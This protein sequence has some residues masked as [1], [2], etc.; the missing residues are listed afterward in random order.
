[1]TRLRVEVT[2]ADHRLGADDAPVT[3]VE[4]GDYQCPYCRAAHATV[5][6]VRARFGSDLRFVFRNFPL[7]TVHPHALRA[8]EV[9]EFAG[10]H[11][12]F[13]EMHDLLFAGQAR[14]GDPLFEDLA[15]QLGLPLPDMA[16]A[17]E[18]R[19]FE[20]RVRDDF[21]G[22]VV[23]GVNGTPTFFIN[24]VRHDR[25][26]AEPELTDAIAQVLAQAV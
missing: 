24:G 7:T 6:R 25:A 10:A 26:P 23:S 18:A 8:A 11:G 13:W 19:T 4:Y 5:A 17:L 20:A 15:G 22:G 3:L 12:R 9:A 1:M 2:A 21:R 14:L 16:R